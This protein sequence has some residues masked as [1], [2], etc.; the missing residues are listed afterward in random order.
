M[1]FRVIFDKDSEEEILAKIH[2]RTALIDDIEKLC[3]N[4]E[5]DVDVIGYY[6]DE[7]FILKP[8]E[9]ECVYVEAGKT[10]AICNDEK[11]YKIRQRLYEVENV[12]PGD[13]IRINKS[14]VANRKRI[15]TFRTDFTGAVSVEFKSGHRDY[16][17]R[18]CFA[19][20]KRRFGL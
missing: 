9:I 5:K 7:I 14:A 12:L 17:S 10:L 13:F 4:D 20:I 2:E 8:D 19:D 1:K 16:V 15:K 3:L 11:I 18:R 6:E